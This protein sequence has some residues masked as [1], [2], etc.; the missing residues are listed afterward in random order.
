MAAPSEWYIARDGKQHGPL[1]PVEL[2]RFV[3]LGHLRPSDLLWH[4]GLSDWRKAEDLSDQLPKPLGKAPLKAPAPRPA[5]PDTAAPAPSASPAPAAP[6]PKP[7]AIAVK[8]AAPAQPVP[9]PVT[10]TVTAEPRPR[11]E[12]RRSDPAPEKPREPAPAAAPAPAPAPATARPAAAQRLGDLP[13]IN[14]AA[15][16]SSLPQ[17]MERTAAAAPSGPAGQAPMPMGAPIPRNGP[18]PQRPVNGAGA[19]GPN[20]NAWNRSAIPPGARPVQHPHPQ[21]RP[22]RD[23]Q[24]AGAP[25]PQLSRPDQLHG[26]RADAGR[27]G[28]GPIADGEPRASAERRDRSVEEP[29]RGSFIGSTLRILALGFG[30]AVVAGGSWWAVSHSGASG[31]LSGAFDRLVGQATAL[32]GLSGPGH[33]KGPTAVVQ[34]PPRVEEI[35]AFQKTPLWQKIRATYPDWYAVRIQEA[36]KLRQGADGDAVVSKYVLDQLV[37][38]RRMHADETLSA[39]PARLMALAQSFL[40][41]VTL[42]EGLSA[43]ACYSFISQGESSAPV[44]E[45]MKSDKVTAGINAQ[46][47]RTIEAAAEGREKKTST[48]AARRSDYDVLTEALTSKAGWTATDL[49]LFSDPR[50]LAKARPEQVCK[51]VKEWFGAQLGLTDEA[52]RM[53]LLVESLRPIVSG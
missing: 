19:P 8:V 16:G 44:V 37:S 20:P 9:Q 4:A 28:P 10:V 13:S 49:Q 32:V 5:V 46:F 24:M 47:E 18:A 21:G 12:A 39:P 7:E 14:P 2:G 48:E 11:P 30:L 51:L 23:P 42:L 31:G 35:F 17:G 22:M 27:M 34:A 1:S 3:E 40:D 26:A 45:S 53:R 43:P 36:A 33:A 25:F 52:V 15:A 50:A 29:S 38:L 6:A 41:N